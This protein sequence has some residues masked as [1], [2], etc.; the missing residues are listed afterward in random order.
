MDLER[1]DGMTP[2][3]ISVGKGMTLWQCQTKKFKS[4]MLSLSFVLPIE[5]ESAYLT[6]LLFSVLLRG[7][8]SYPTVSAMN[9][10]LDYLYGTEL[11]VRNFYRGDCRILGLSAN[12]LG[13][14]YLFDGNSEE[15][16]SDVLAMMR[17]IF[18]FPAL[19]ENGLLNPRYVESE[20]ELQ[21]DTIRA[22]KNNPH[23]YASD[24][25][26][27][28]M[29][30]NEPSGTP[31][32][33]TEAQVQAVTPALLTAH[34]KKL[35]TL[36]RPCFF[37]VGAQEGK[38]VARVIERVFGDLSFPKG[39]SSEAFFAGRPEKREPRR[40]EESLPVSQGHLVIGLRTEAKVTN[41]DDFYAMTLCNEILGASPVSKLF[42]NVREKKSLCYSCSSAYNIYKGGLL[43]SCGLEND[44]REEA[45]EE[46]LRQ[47]EA[48]RKG[49]F[50]EEE[51]QS[52]KKSLENAYRQ[53][54]DSPAAI[55][56]Y[57][58]GRFLAGVRD[59]L[60]ECRRRL[61]EVTREQVICAANGLYTDTVFFL[62]P[63]KTGE[64]CDDEE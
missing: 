44:R 37:Y 60:M 5:R 33:G 21:C 43:I 50:D 15:L 30:E 46:I 27:A 14:C 19:D 22:Q 38:V 42:V 12:L 51:W 45:E 11:S 2:N 1:E 61:A 16:L 8:Q 63:T 49:D 40:F 39:V 64:E 13:G 7:T 35:C 34:W 29:Y 32:Y 25:C 26:R 54:E 3:V 53:L 9:R 58:F 56:S 41:G 10:R 18:F 47:I 23:A 28:L 4:E 17:E 6:S 55:E 20:K 36:L 52:A 31:I 62:K 59:S 48:L 24:R 57:Y